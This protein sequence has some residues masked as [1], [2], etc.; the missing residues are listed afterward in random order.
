MG[1]S[2]LGRIYLRLL[3]A[4][5]APASGWAALNLV[6][7]STATFVLA[8]ETILSALVPLEMLALRCP[9]V[10]HHIML[11]GHLARQSAA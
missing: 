3:A 1:Q 6:A 2:P 7:P 11:H 10:H 5:F 8:T 9:G 4:S